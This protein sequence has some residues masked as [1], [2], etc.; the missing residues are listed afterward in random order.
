M[1]LILQISFLIVKFLI[2]IDYLL[3]FILINIY[4]Y[5]YNVLKSN[6]IYEKGETQ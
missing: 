4:K 1:I 6:Y 2:L 5:E 3:I